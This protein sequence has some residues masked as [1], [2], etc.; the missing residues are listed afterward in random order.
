MAILGLS[1]EAISTNDVKPENIM[2]MLKP[3]ADGSGSNLHVKLLDLGSA[4]IRLVC[5]C[6]GTIYRG[7]GAES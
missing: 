2:V 4:T 6:F 1:N 7:H 3:A 5:K